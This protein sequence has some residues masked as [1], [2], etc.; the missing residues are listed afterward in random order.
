[1]FIADKWHIVEKEKVSDGVRL[2]L[3]KQ[4]RVAD[5]T[6]IR[7]RIVPKSSFYTTRSTVGNFDDVLQTHQ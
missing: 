4:I 3:L 5:E 6:R 2:T 7:L 1:L